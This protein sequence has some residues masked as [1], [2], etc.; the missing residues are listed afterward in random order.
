MAKKKTKAPEPQL[1]HKSIGARR[2]KLREYVN[3]A[4]Y[5]QAVCGFLFAQS[6]LAPTPSGVRALRDLIRAFVRGDKQAS[7]LQKLMLRTID[8]AC[9]GVFKQEFTNKY[10]ASGNQTPAVFDEIFAQLHE[11]SS[12]LWLAHRTPQPGPKPQPKPPAY[13]ECVLTL[14]VKY[15]PG[16]TYPEALAVALDRLMQTATSTTGILDEYGE[17]VI[18]DF[19][20]PPSIQPPFD[21]WQG[22][23]LPETGG[24]IGNINGLAGVKFPD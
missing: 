9:K 16:K 6:S 12:S 18:G 21:L 10:H 11:L 19:F 3:E 2:E 14:S 24:A 7:T 20:V 5:R 23:P 4:P 13:A 1:L 22:V 8:D 17:V 15:Q